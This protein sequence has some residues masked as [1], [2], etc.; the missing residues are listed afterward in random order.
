MGTWLLIL[1]CSGDPMACI[2]VLGPWKEARFGSQARCLVQ[3][4]SIVQ[5]AARTNSND[6]IEITYSCRPY[7]EEDAKKAGK[8]KD[9]DDKKT[10]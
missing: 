6:N 4:E 8:A 7:T 3:G 5:T 2:A 1:S 9:E 10:N